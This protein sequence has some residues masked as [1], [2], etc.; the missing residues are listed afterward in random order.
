MKGIMEGKI[1]DMDGIVTDVDYKNNRFTLKT[2]RPPGV[3]EEYV[4]YADRKTEFVFLT[5]E[6]DEGFVDDFEFGPTVEYE[7]KEEENPA[8]FGDVKMGENVL[9]FFEERVDPDKDFR[10]T[11]KTV[12]I[13]RQINNINEDEIYEKDF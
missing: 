6:I 12:K 8:S 7:R 1:R 13:F 5:E 3:Y 11:A 9:I 4:V 2:L 10:L